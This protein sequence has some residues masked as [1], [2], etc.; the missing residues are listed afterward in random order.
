M[1]ILDGSVAHRKLDGPVGPMLPKLDLNDIRL[2]MLVTQHGSFTAASRAS[3]I[4]KSTIS[5]RIS[6]LEQTIGTGLIRRTSRAFSLTE[7]GAMLL[8]HARAI[9]ELA[10]N[11]EHTFLDRGKNLTGTLNIA[12]CNALAQFVL[13]SL[14]SRVLETNP[15][16]TIRV[17]ATNNYVD[18]IGG[19]FDLAIRNHR[20]QLKDSILMQR[21]VARV[22]WCLVAAP[23]W[24][25]KNGAPKCP[26]ELSAGQGI[27]FATRHESQTW[28]LFRGDEKTV[29]E[30]APRLTFDDLAALH[31]A[32]LVGGGIACLPTYIVSSS[33]RS[34]LLHRVLTD[35]IP[36]L[37]TL[38][39]I[40]PPKLQ[41]SRLA[42]SFS[43]FLA[44][45][46]PKVIYREDGS[47]V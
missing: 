18:L 12:S 42:R 8:P 45:E 26:D 40:T 10:K 20:E 27:L 43:D 4:P 30:L 9:E 16:V 11:L 39:I 5:Q 24:L 36:T 19:G 44:A 7:A 23:I 21:V 13:P 25:E 6:A 33:L 3:G 35:W 32:T 22:P 17:E 46:L 28:T 38:S 47:K 15:D 1:L 29:V 31:A 41:S 34:G 37:S 14:T 2:L